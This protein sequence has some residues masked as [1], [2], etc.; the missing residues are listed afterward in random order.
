MMDIVDGKIKEIREAVG[1]ESR[2]ALVA[3]YGACAI[4]ERNHREIHR[5]CRFSRPH[6][7][8]FSNSQ[9][10]RICASAVAVN[11]SSAPAH[12]MQAPLPGTD[13]LT[14]LGL[15]LINQ[16]PLRM[17]SA[18]VPGAGHHCAGAA[19]G[20]RCAHRW[21]RRVINQPALRSLAAWVPRTDDM[22][23]FSIVRSAHIRA[24]SIL[25]RKY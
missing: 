1:R 9:A 4:A 20:H 3:R 25:R 23:A 18:R 15:R 16:A 12:H 2:L 10:K 17:R 6:M 7:R 14:T 22:R 5:W 8:A 19:A 24:F 11:K 13:A 21:G